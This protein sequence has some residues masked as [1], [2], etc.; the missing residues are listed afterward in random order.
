MQTK[1]FHGLSSITLT[2]LPF[3]SSPNFA[4]FFFFFLQSTLTLRCSIFSYDLPFKLSSN[5]VRFRAIALFFIY[6]KFEWM[7]LDWDGIWFCSIIWRVL[8]WLSIL[9]YQFDETKLDLYIQILTGLNYRTFLLH[10][11]LWFDKKSDIWYILYAKC[12]HVDLFLVT[13]FLLYILW[14]SLCKF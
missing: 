4:P 8:Q 11:T 12:V 5:S 9:G 6:F 7:C 10:S 1:Y 3:E 2:H 14:N 13:A